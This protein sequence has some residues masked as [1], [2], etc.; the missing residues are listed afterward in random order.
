MWEGYISWGC[1]EKSGGNVPSGQ[2]ASRRGGWHFRGSQPGCPADVGWLWPRVER[3]GA[4]SR[5]P[6]PAFGWRRFQA[7]AAGPALC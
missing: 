1:E 3:G 6:R 5:V 7:A 2:E 4:G